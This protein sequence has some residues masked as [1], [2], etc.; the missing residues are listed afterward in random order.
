M[1]PINRWNEKVR[2]KKKKETVMA[3]EKKNTI[4]EEHILEIMS[5]S[6]FTDEKMG[7]KTT[8][9]CCVLPNGFEIIESSGCVDADNYD[10]E[11]NV[12]QHIIMRYQLRKHDNILNLCQKITIK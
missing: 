8:V 6:T 4:T 10:G 1:K 9:V 12:G 2:K 3:N 11:L 5:K 7:D